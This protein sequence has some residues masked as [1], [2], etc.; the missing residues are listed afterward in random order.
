MI[1]AAT[2]PRLATKARLRRDR[3]SDA[4]VLLSPERGLVLNG[5]AAAVA[6]L[7]TGEHTLGDIIDRIASR[8]TAER[9]FIAA[10]V[11]A[12]VDDLEQRGLVVVS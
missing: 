12:F 2:R 11:Q 5:T 9:A 6:V 4:L 8:Y 1:A 10:E 3:I 7:L